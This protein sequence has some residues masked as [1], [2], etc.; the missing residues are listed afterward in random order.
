MQGTTR[1][2][3]GRLSQ[4]PYSG[5]Q[6]DYQVPAMLKWKSMD[7]FN[8]AATSDIA[9]VVVGDVKHLTS[10][11]P[12]LLKGSLVASSEVGENME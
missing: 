12:I 3:R 5:R 8:A 10:A 7:D 11:E 1:R 9:Q 2:G 6:G 4:Q